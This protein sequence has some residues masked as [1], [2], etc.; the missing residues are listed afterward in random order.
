M[1]ITSGAEFLISSMSCECS[2]LALF[3]EL[4]FSKVR[5][6]SV[7]DEDAGDGER[8]AFVFSKLYALTFINEGISF[9]LNVFDTSGNL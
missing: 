7:F 5:S 2:I 4:L 1:I 8:C 6:F 9:R 3:L